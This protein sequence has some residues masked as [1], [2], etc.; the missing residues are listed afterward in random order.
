MKTMCDYSKK[1]PDNLSFFVEQSKSASHV[2]GKC[3]RFATSKE[4]LCKPKKIS[5]IEAKL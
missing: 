4:M 2:C 5:E 1:L 3:G